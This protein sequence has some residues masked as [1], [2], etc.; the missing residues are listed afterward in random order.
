MLHNP[1]LNRRSLTSQ[2]QVFVKVKVVLKIPCSMGFWNIMFLKI[3]IGCFDFWDF[4]NIK[5][6]GFENPGNFTDSFT[7]EMT[8]T[9]SID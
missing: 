5:A 1:E 8:I 9:R 7:E 6:E 4:A 2:K 3:V